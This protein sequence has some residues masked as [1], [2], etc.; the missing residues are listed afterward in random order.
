MQWYLNRIS[1]F[2][3]GELPSNAPTGVFSARTEENVREFQR[4]FNL[5]QTGIIN[6]ETWNRIVSVYYSLLQNFPEEEAV[7]ES[8]PGEP[9][10]QGSEGENVLYIQKAL[11]SIRNVISGINYVSEDG[12]YGPA[13]AAA[14]RQ[15]QTFFSLTPDGIVGPQT[16][17]RIAEIYYA[18][19]IPS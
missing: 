11:N 14:V 4:Y 18:T 16:W 13:T 12:K 8:Y 17:R 1:Y 9:L 5:P 10:R 19:L 2:L 3:E 15:F 6:E 7:L